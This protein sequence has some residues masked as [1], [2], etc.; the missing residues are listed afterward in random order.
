MKKV[1]IT[2]LKK[3]R[4][5]ISRLTVT[6][7]KYGLSSD[8]HFWT[9]ELKNMAWLAAVEPLA[10]PGVSLWVLVGAREDLTPEIR[11]GLTLLNLSATAKNHGLALLW[12][13]T[14]SGLETDMLPSVFAGA[15]ILGIASPGIGAKLAAKANMPPKVADSDFRLAIHANPGYGV[16][17]ETGP[18]AGH[19][20]KG[21]ILALNSGEIKAHGVGPRG[22]IPE[23][24]TLEYPMMGL[25]LKLGNTELTGWAV[26]NN[27]DPASSYY[28]KIDG[29]PGC[30]VFGSFTEDDDTEMHVLRLQP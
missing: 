22:K 27:L 7:H 18:T 28:S 30:I 24:C 16:W 21:A 11:Y 29:I 14:G 17:F 10:D 15:E 25:K 8:G 4:E 20:W 26:Q 2:A 12:L 5:T 3:D 1:W 23:K 6:A 13:D 19:E 9:D